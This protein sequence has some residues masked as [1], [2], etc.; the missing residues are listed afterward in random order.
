[1][2]LFIAVAFCCVL[3]TALT[4]APTTST[5]TSQMG[6]LCPYNPVCWASFHSPAEAA[7]FVAEQL[8]KLEELANAN[9]DDDD[10][11]GQSG[12][13][14][15]RPTRGLRGWRFR[16]YFRKLP[17]FGSAVRCKCVQ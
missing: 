13:L 8:A 14:E 5:M 4:A 16:S 11:E 12:L 7:E 1:M 9:D 17:R 2:K 3:A 10:E 6:P 15:A